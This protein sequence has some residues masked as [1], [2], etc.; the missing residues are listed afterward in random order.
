MRVMEVMLRQATPMGDQHVAMVRGLVTARV[1]T[2]TRVSPP[3]TLP[4][5]G[6]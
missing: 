2:L 5:F 4:Y 3:L 1:E 6:G